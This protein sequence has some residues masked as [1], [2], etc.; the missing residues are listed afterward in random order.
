MIYVWKELTCRYG[1]RFTAQHPR[2]EDSL[3]VWSEVL[4]EI[5]A[6]DLK[7]GLDN[8]PPSFP[9]TAMEFRL[10]CRPKK[11]AAH[12]PYQQAALPKTTWLDR[13]KTAKKQLEAIRTELKKK[14]I[15]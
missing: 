5:G 2:V 7:Y 10:I 6:N 3:V 13:R 4:S 14:E 9:P 12:K 11:E 8:L 15:E 1:S